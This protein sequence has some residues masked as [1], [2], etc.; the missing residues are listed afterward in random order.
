MCDLCERQKGKEYK[1]IS[2][3]FVCIVH[4]CHACHGASDGL[5]EHPDIDVQVPEVMLALLQQVPCHA[6]NSVVPA[7]RCVDVWGYWQ[8]GK[9]KH[10]HWALEHCF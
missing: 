7:G 6:G 2:Q 5:S 8:G 3:G 9:A 1:W 10:G 4:E